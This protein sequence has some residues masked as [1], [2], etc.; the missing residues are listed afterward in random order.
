M[1]DLN[2]KTVSEL[3][4]LAKAAGINKYGNMNKGELIAALSPVISIDPAKEGT[5]ETVLVSK[6]QE[7]QVV[8]VQKIESSPKGSDLEQ[9][10][11]FAKFK[12]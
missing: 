12:R 1:Q 5:D 8:T 3:K 9:H 11:K 4:E 7:N 6:D 2:S 10:P